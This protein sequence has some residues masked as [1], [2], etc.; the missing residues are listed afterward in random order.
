MKLLNQALNDFKT[1]VFVDFEGTQ[2]TQ[3]IIAIGAIKV[4]LDNKNKICKKYNSFK[5]F[6]KASGE[7]GKIVVKLTGITDDYLKENGVSFE[8]GIAKFE[9]YVGK[10]TN[11]IKYL[12]YGNF[13]MRLLHQS[14]A[15]SLEGETPFIKTIY[16]NHIDFANILQYY[17]R[18]NNNEQLSLLDALKIFQVTP[19]ADAHNPETDAKNLMLLFDATTTKQSILKEVYKQVLANN[20]HLPNP[21]NKA[22]KK[23]MKE[24]KVSKEEFERFIEEDI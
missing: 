13:D 5:V 12:S 18:S 8:Q 2:Y 1:I 10:T 24:G 23:M 9:K 4:E 6:T 22:I 20:P 15:N 14:V 16:K 17:I 11:R 21:V 7:V 19:L 3:E